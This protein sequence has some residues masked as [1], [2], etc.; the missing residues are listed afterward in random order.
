MSIENISSRLPE[1]QCK[2]LVQQC[3]D[4]LIK[5]LGSGTEQAELCRLRCSA[6]TVI[7][8]WAA[9]GKGVAAAMRKQGGQKLLRVLSRTLAAD[10]AIIVVVC[11]HALLHLSDH[12]PM[13]VGLALKA[14]PGALSRLLVQLDG[15]VRIMLGG[16]R[17]ITLQASAIQA[18]PNQP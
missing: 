6:V 11:T 13:E 9:A 17:G 5:L 2:V 3:L 4:S 18:G 12:Y 7:G 16:L 14:V 8:I 15:E 1:Q 10:T